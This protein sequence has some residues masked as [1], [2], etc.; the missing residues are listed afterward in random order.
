MK[1]HLASAGFALGALVLFWLLLFPK[2]ER[3]QSVVPQPVSSEAG[4]AG[5]LGLTRWLEAEHVPLV[6][7]RGRY[8]RLDVPG[9]LP[10]GTGNVLVTTMPHALP[11]RAA[12]RPSL[13][14]WVQRGNTL[15]V[16][17][18]LAD[19]PPWSLIAD[20]TFL[21]QVRQVAQIEVQAFD[22]KPVAKLLAPAHVVLQPMTTAAG[23]HPLLAGVGSIATVS[24]L[25]AS[26]FR[27]VPVDDAPLLA[28]ARRVDNGD[29]AV[30]LRALGRGVIVL[31]AYA[32][33]FSNEALGDADNARWFAAVVAQ[34]LGR[35][36]R[37]LLDDAHQGIVD[38]YDSHAFFADPRLH[39]SLG[40][41]VL[42]WLV[43]VLGA[44]SLAP[45]GAGGTRVDDAAM[46]K[47]SAGFY[48]HALSPAATAAR[49]FEHFFNS[50]RRRLHLR[51]NGAPVWDW[52]ERQAR[53]PG[54]RLT[55]LR[56]LHAR[57]A[58]GRAV[59]LVRVQTLLSSLSESLT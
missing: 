41:I 15:V 40:W 30:W 25:P 19:T 34:R 44:R 35:G 20:Q 49:L 9:V 29:D 1:E 18:A 16:L 8:T 54:E 21:A 45:A 14:R 3:S 4:A 46:L 2:P 57:A 26:R 22:T 17:A 52:L 42:A 5:Y 13:E 7:W 47:V 32:S 53:V 48:T 31:S 6:V 58:A 37:V 27:A 11:V 59:N 28:L 10:S 23:P 33:P 36:G 56:R 24:E 38:Y 51:E 12:E 43:F 50:L 39:G 55:E